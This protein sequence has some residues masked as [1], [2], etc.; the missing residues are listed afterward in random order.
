VTTR[1]VSESICQA[2]PAEA[3]SC[4][5]W[6]INSW[7]L[8]SPALTCRTDAGLTLNRRPFK[9]DRCLPSNVRGPV[10]FRQGW[11]SS[12]SSR[13]C[14]RSASVH[15]RRLE[16]LTRPAATRRGFLGLLLSGSGVI[17]SMFMGSTCLFVFVQ[18]NVALFTPMIDIAHPLAVGQVLL[19]DDRERLLTW[20][21][22]VGPDWQRQPPHLTQ[23]P[24]CRGVEHPDHLRVFGGGGLG[25]E[26]KKTAS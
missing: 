7:M 12:A 26:L 5:N 20:R 6:W 16:V 4:A 25:M 22:A 24:G 17:G 9:A 3:R 2:A 1:G 14:L 15:A 10:D 19:S 18:S 21:L 8:S 11:C 13:K 23:Q